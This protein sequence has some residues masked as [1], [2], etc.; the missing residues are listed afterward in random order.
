MSGVGEGCWSFMLDWWEECGGGGGGR[1]IGMGLASTWLP[2][3][4]EIQLN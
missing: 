3:K 2:E 1:R 4:S